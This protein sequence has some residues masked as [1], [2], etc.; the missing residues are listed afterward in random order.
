MYKRWKVV[1]ALIIEDNG[2]DQLIKAKCGKL[3]QESSPEVEDLY[4]ETTRR[5]ADGNSLTPEGI[6]HRNQGLD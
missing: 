1:L 3:Y 4:E 2:G 6:D 5:A